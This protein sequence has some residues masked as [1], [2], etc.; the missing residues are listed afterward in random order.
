M[1]VDEFKVLLKSKSIGRTQLPDDTDLYQRIQTA[2]KRIAMDTVPL[3]LSKTV[4]VGTLVTF[5]V[6]RK[7]DETS[8]IRTPSIAVTLDDDVDIDS[9]LLDA[10]ALYVMAGL[11][12]PNGKTHMGLY[13][14]EIEVN[15]DRLV[16]TVLSDNDNDCAERYQ[17]FP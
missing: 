13:Y 2:C 7:L 10:V 4:P 11:E 14:R 8:Y 12:R 16:E 3:R 5:P 15:N 6:Y 9:V 1:T 17:Q